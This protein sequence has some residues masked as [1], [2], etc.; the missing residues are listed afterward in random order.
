MA[1]TID[2]TH[3]QALAA[4]GEAEHDPRVLAEVEALV[5]RVLAGGAAVTLN[6]YDFYPTPD[7]VITQALDALAVTGYE[8]ETI[9]EPSCGT[10]AW[11]AEIGRRWPAARVDVAEKNPL[12]RLALKDRGV[13]LVADD[14]LR[15]RPDHRYDLIVGNPPFGD[16]NDKLAWAKHLAH[17]QSLLTARGQMMMI[18]PAGLA[19]RKERAIAELRAA[20]R[21]AEVPPD[22]FRES[23]TGANT[24]LAWYSPDQSLT[25]RLRV[26]RSETDFPTEP[27]IPEAITDPAL[28]A[29]NLTRSLRAVDRIIDRLTAPPRQMDIAWSEEGFQG[30]RNFATWYAHTIVD[31]HRLSNEAMRCLIPSFKGTRRTRSIRLREYFWRFCQSTMIEDQMRQALKEIGA[32][33]AE[34]DWEAL[35]DEWDRAVEVG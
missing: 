13:N 21:T 6:R 15:Y 14:F 11:L 8:P 3:L 10:G 27:P 35:V 30:F 5:G 7:A 32:T 34:I 17:A 4:A 22:A 28:I 29:R 19:F 20:F 26:A 18:A 16:E 9:L 2:L 24:L 12:N 1:T 23:G 31:Q 33:E 25:P